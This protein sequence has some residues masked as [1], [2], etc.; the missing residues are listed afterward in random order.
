MAREMGTPVCLPSSGATEYT[1]GL[2]PPEVHELRAGGKVTLQ[3]KNGMQF[4]EAMD[5][6]LSHEQR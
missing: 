2:I 3:R 1:M 5:S 6:G 4:P